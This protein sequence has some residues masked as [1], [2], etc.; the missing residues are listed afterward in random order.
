ME[1]DRELFIDHR[2]PTGEVVVKGQFWELKK[3]GKKP[4]RYVLCSEEEK[5]YKKTSKGRIER[6]SKEQHN[7]LL[8]LYESKLSELIKESE[9]K[10]VAKIKSR[11]VSVLMRDWLEYVGAKGAETTK[12]AYQITV[13]YY[14]AAV[15]D[16]NIEDYDH[17]KYV[18]FLKYLKKIPNRIDGTL[19]DIRIR[20]H[21]RHLRAFYNWC[22]KHRILD[23]AYY[24][25]LPQE[26]KKEQRPYESHELTRLK[27]TMEKLVASAERKNHRK[28][29]IND[30]RA[31]VIFAYTGM[32][33]GAIWSLR[34]DHIDL[35]RRVIKIRKNV[36]LN[37][38]NK[39]LK[40]RDKPISSILFEYLKKDL[41]DRG[42]R[43]VYYLDDGLGRPCYR[44]PAGLTKAFTRARDEAGFPKEIKP[45]KAIRNHGVNMLVDL[46]IKMKIAQ[47]FFDHE[48]IT[49]T[50]GY[51]N[52]RQ[53][54][55]QTRDAA[56]LVTI[57][58]EDDL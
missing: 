3:P 34:L 55:S 5:I 20:G 4:P 23:R 26:T 58:W 57:G 36:E 13:N 37:W 25:E 49:T 43:E 51:T 1:R 22:F 35:D 40:E 30:L 10:E 16:H 19:S 29:R 44:T 17:H 42:E 11:F 56:E 33:R 39:K 21:F 54:E 28:C 27:K 14:L 18:S 32:R 41:S 12:Y 45:I 6:S 2:Y 24:I 38:Q 52:R 15:S 46:G 9:K 47:Q 48:S 53:F 50:D 31:L 8:S 7:Y